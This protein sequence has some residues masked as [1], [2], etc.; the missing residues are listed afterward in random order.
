MK[1]FSELKNKGLV[2]DAS[3]VENPN[4][5]LWGQSG[6]HS[7]VYYP[8]EKLDQWHLHDAAV[9]LMKAIDPNR[10]MS[11]DEFVDAVDMTEPQRQACLSLLLLF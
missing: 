3:G 10:V 7:K 9:C 8:I 6:L 4:A 5:W 2:Y 11:L 1:T